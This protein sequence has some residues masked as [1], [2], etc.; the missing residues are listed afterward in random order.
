MIRAVI[1]DIEGTT[2]SI[3]FVHDVLFP[4]AAAQLEPFVRARGGDPVVQATLAELGQAS[5]A[6]DPVAVARDLMARDVKSTPLKR[7]QGWIWEAGYADGSLLADVYPDV[8]PQLRAW[9]DAGLTLAVY[10]SGSVHAQKLLFGHTRAG[11]LRALFTGWFDT[12]TGPKTEPASYA[13]IATVLDVRPAEALFLSDAT[14]ELEA[15]R[16]AGL[17][18]VGISRGA[19]V[20]PGWLTSFAELQLE[21][22]GSPER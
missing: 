20:P 10:S 8:A 21:A 6:G 15:A 22:A 14:R 1:T 9:R 16:G 7:L 19:E 2:T 13:R 3:A 4:Y 17:Q 11:D 12:T 5:P 18:A